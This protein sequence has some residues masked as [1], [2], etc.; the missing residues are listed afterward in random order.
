MA[1]FYSSV[2]LEKRGFCNWH[3]TNFCELSV[4]IQTLGYRFVLGFLFNPWDYVDVPHEGAL[5]CSTPGRAHL[6]LCCKPGTELNRE[7]M[8]YKEGEKYNKVAE[9]PF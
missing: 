5:F 7:R 8:L 2:F 4:E 9:M 1:Y 3:R 6:G